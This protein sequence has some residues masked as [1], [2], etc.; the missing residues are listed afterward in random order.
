MHTDI[1]DHKPI[2]LKP[3]RITLAHIKWSVEEIDI[4]LKVGTIKQSTI[5]WSSPV[6]LVSKVG[7]LRLC[8][9][10]IK[11]NCLTTQCK[12]P[13]AFIDEIFPNL[14]KSEHSSSLERRWGYPHMTLDDESILVAAF[15]TTKGKY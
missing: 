1:G 8:T 5:L 14:G 4:L 7:G 2:E 13:L 12:L 6:V 15:I 11:L 9:D 3:Y 10:F